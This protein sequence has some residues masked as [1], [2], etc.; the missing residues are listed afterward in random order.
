MSEQDIR[1]ELGLCHVINVAGMMT[2]LG[3]SIAAR[4]ARLQQLGRHHRAGTRDRAR[5]QE[6][7]RQRSL[8]AWNVSLQE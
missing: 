5:T 3:A 1:A 8:H 6:Q 7:H 2:G 4:P